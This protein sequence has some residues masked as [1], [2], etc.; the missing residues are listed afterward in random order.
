MIS[1]RFLP[2]DDV[3]ELIKRIF[4]PGYEAARRHFQSALDA[5]VLSNS[6][7]YGYWWQGDLARVLQFAEGQ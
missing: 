1:E 4:I 7:A 6:V 3:L 5:D 2:P